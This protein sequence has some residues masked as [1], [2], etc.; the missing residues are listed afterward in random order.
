MHNLYFKARSRV[1]F[2][3]TS[4]FSLTY[5]SFPSMSKLDEA[6]HH[7]MLVFT[8]SLCFCSYARPF[9]HVGNN[10]RRGNVFRVNIYGKSNDC[11]TFS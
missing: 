4:L 11:L 8:L 10:S 9:C 2:V 5:L 6:E 7:G 3:D 1:C